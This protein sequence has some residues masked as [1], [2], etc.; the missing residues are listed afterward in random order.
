[1]GEGLHYLAYSLTR[2]PAEEIRGA[3]AEASAKSWSELQSLDKIVEN[4]LPEG[5]EAEVVDAPI[6]YENNSASY[7]AEAAELPSNYQ[8]SGY[9]S[10]TDD[11]DDAEVSYS[12]NVDTAWEQAGET[13]E[14]QV[15]ERVRARILKLGYEERFVSSEQ[16]ERVENYTMVVGFGMNCIL[17]DIKAATQ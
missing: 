15:E 5:I 12:G 7:R 3:L 4:S 13:Y 17:Y 9:K 2:D 6:T 8:D 14:R 1:M 11:D 16:K 10:A